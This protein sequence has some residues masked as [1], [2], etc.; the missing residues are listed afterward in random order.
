MEYIVMPEESCFPLSGRLTS[1]HG[2]ISEPLAIGVYAVKKSG[3]VKGLDIGIL[4][5]G[6]IGMS[7]MLAARAEGAGSFTVTDKIQPRLAMA[8]K[9]RCNITFQSI[10]R[11]FYSNVK[12][13]PSFRP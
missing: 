10:G 12:T 1:D 5:Y 4:G 2:A 9:G 6:P 7:V 3:G 8:L 13:A 11:R